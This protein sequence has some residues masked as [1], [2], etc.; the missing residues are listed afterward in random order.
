MRG[1]HEEA[2]ETVVRDLFRFLDARDLPAFMGLFEPGAEIVHDDG[3]TT[4]PGRFVDALRAGPSEPPRSRTLSGLR[5]GV[6]STLAWAGY[7]NRVTFDV[8][9]G[10]SRAL[11]FTETAV[12]SRS[13]EGW[14][15]V[16]LHYSGNRRA[17]P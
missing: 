10:P 2:V 12:L 5:V 17:G 11:N 16:R 15:V 1:N 7:E 13:P 6:G 14:R 9:G 4:S 3:Q 8:P